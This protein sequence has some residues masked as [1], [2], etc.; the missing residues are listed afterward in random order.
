MTLGVV[1]GSVF[2]LEVTVSMFSVQWH[3]KASKSSIPLFFRR[4]GGV[5]SHF[6]LSQSTMYSSVTTLPPVSLHF[7][8]L[9]QNILS[10]QT[11]KHVSVLQS[12]RTE[13]VTV[14]LS[15]W[16]PVVLVSGECDPFAAVNSAG[17]HVEKRAGVSSMLPIFLKRYVVQIICTTWLSY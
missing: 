17:Q 5:L 11:N 7:S 12:T 10:F 8:F 15:F 1:Y 4:E 16:C 14:I 6:S 13:S 3:L 9:F 2:G